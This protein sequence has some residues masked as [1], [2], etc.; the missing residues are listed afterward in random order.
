LKLVLLPGMDGTG[1]LFSEFIAALPEPF[2]VVAV[3]YPTE[4]YLPYSELENFVRAASPISEPYMLVAESFST[5]LA[6]QYA[7]TNPANLEGLVL[8][9]GFATSPVKGWRRFLGSLLAP[10]VF[11]VPLPNLAAKL[12]L[13][14]SDAPTSLLTAVRS[15]ISS[16]QAGVLVA[17]LRAVLASDVRWA[18]GQIGVPILYIRAEQDRLVS[19]LCVEEL[20]QIRPEMSV[21]VLAGPHLLLQRRPQR[22]AEAVVRFIRSCCPSGVA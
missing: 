4:R 3:G 19:A 16:V 18:V 17:R 10:L 5:P 14:G 7:A 6:I 9:A 15:A 22:A 20:R 8:C 1:K 13:V 12:W 2:E 11:R 21:A